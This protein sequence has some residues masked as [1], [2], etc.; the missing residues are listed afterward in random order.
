MSQRYDD[1]GVDP[2]DK[3][4]K[5]DDEDDYSYEPMPTR[6]P[7]S[8]FSQEPDIMLY[9][10]LSDRDEE[11]LIMATLVHNMDTNFNSSQSFDQALQNA[12]HQQHTAE[13]QHSDALEYVLEWAKQSLQFLYDEGA[14]HP[15][16]F[17]GYYNK[18]REGYFDLA[19][20]L[21]EMASKPSERLDFD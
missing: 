19:R 21:I 17:M 12:T 14:L 7:L 6:H 20:A 16:E 15:V 9:G 2:H 10:P 5:E 4:K 8:E 3:R 11:R 13:E 18:L 1:E